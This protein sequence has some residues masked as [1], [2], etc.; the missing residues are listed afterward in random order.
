MKKLLRAAG[1]A[2]ERGGG[3]IADERG[4][5]KPRGGPDEA[6]ARP[7]FH[8]AA[9]FRSHGKMIPS[10]RR[11]SKPPA[12]KNAAGGLCSENDGVQTLY[13]RTIT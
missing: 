8:A 6:R 13:S 2:S 12:A 1:G 10:R 11:E 7:L 9:P 3:V 4:R 5:E